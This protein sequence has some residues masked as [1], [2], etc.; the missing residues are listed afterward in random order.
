MFKSFI[1][2]NDFWKPFSSAQQ[3]KLLKFWSKL[4]S[5]A[6]LS[7]LLLIFSGEKNAKS[8][9]SL[10]RETADFCRFIFWLD[11]CKYNAWYC[12]WVSVELKDVGTEK[13]ILMNSFSHFQ[14]F[15]KQPDKET[16]QI[17]ETGL[18]KASIVF[19]NRK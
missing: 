11:N 13:I 16:P 3:G 12:V 8:L 17:R 14:F 1:F 4:F 9:I 10:C 7:C 18:N 2:Q 5:L 15:T 19:S 6:H